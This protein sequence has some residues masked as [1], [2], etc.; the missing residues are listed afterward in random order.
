[1][2]SFTRMSPFTRVLF[3]AV[4]LASVGVLFFGQRVRPHRSRMVGLERNLQSAQSEVASAET[5]I[6]QLR[7]Q[8]EEAS[9][10]A[11]L[12]RAIS[13]Q[14]TGRSL[15]DLIAACAAPG[16]QVEILKFTVHDAESGDG[17][18]RRRIELGLRGGFGPVLALLHD[19]ER[20]FPPIELVTSELHM[21]EVESARAGVVQADLVGVLYEAR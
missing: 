15:H 9:R 11:S 19:L 5:R 16:S 21:P 13:A 14:T 7:A 8:T 2:N 10:Y 4:M 20:A 17:V 12:S 6:E 3:A 18:G 1:M